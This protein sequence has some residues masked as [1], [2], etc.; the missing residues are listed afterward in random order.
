MDDNNFLKMGYKI[1]YERHKRG[2]SQLDFALK[3]GLTTRS[4]SRIECG[5]NDPRVSTMMKIAEAFEMELSELFTF[6]F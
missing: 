2:L 6:Q 5:T 4:L 3:A 1:K